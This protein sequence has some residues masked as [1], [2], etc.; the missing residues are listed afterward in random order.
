MNSLSL[1]QME[2][3]EYRDDEELLSLSLGIVTDSSVDQRRRKRK[4]KDASIPTH[5]F[6]GCD[7]KIFSLLQVREQ[8]L[9]LDHKRIKSRRWKWPQPDSFAANN[10]HCSGS[11]QG[12]LGV[13]ESE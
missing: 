10:S 11:K 7:G 2:T 5:P 12:G 1:S 3:I 13:G 6:E 9:K 8:M 4:R